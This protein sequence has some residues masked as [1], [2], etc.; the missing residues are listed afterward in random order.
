MAQEDSKERVRQMQRIAEAGLSKI[1]KEQGIKQAVLPFV[2]PITLAIDLAKGAAQAVPQ[3]AIACAVVSFA[4]QLSLNPIEESKK[5]Q[6]G[7][8]HV[9]DR[10]Q[11]YTEL[12]PLTLRFGQNLDKSFEKIRT[13]LKY[14]VVQVYKE[15]LLFLMKSVCWC[16][17]S[18]VVA[19]LRDTI[20]LNDWDG[21]T[22][23]LKEAEADLE[24]HSRLLRGHE[25]LSHV[26]DIESNTLVIK[27]QLTGMLSMQQSL[28][29]EQCLQDLFITYPEYDKQRIESIKG[30]LLRD[31]CR[32]VLQNDSFR[33][34]RDGQENRLLWIK[35]DPGK[36]KTMLL[37]GIIDEL[38][39]SVSKTDRLAYFYCQATDLRINNGVAVLRGLV[40]MLAREHQELLCHVQKKHSGASKSVFQD[41]NAWF[42]L[43]DILSNMIQNSNLG[44]TY[45]VIDALDECI[46]GQQE[47]LELIVELSSKIRSVKWIVSSRNLQ[48]IGDVLETATRDLTISLELNHSSV[49][50]AVE[51]YTKHKVQEL[52]RKKR[53]GKE[54]RTAVLKHLLANA[55]GTFLWVAL[56]C[57]RFPPGLD[58]LYQRMM[59]LVNQSEDGELCKQILACVATVYRPL[60]LEEMAEG[61]TES[62]MQSI[63]SLCGSFITS[64]Q[65][66]RTIQFVHQSAKD[67]LLDH[68]GQWLGPALLKAHE[69]IFHQSLRAMGT[70][71][72]EDVYT[73]LD[74]AFPIQ[75]IETPRPDPLQA[76]RYSC[77]YWV[78]HLV[79]WDPQAHGSDTLLQAFKGV[80]L[81]LRRKLLQW[82]ESLS[83]IRS[84]SEG[85]LALLKLLELLQLYS[86]ALI[87]SPN[88]SLTR[89]Q[90]ERD[91]EIEWMTLKPK[92]ADEWD[93]HRQTLQGH[94]DHVRSIAFSPD[95]SLVASSSEDCSIRIWKFA[96][97]S[98]LQI[99]TGHSE[100]VHSTAFSHDGKIVV[101]GSYDGTIKVW[102]L[103]D[104]KCLQTLA[105]DHTKRVTESKGPSEMNGVRSIGGQNIHQHAWPTSPAEA[106][107]PLSRVWVAFVNNYHS[108][109]DIE[110]QNLSRMS[111]TKFQVN[112]AQ[113]KYSDP[114]FS[115]DGTL[116]LLTTSKQRTLWQTT[117][118]TCL[119]RLDLG[120]YVSGFHDVI[121]PN[122]E[123][124]AVK[125]RQ[126]IQVIHISTKAVIQTLKGLGFEGPTL[127]F[128]PD[129]RFLASGFQDGTVKIW[130]LSVG[131][132][133]SIEAHSERV[134]TVHCSETDNTVVSIS[135]NDIMTWDPAGRRTSQSVDPHVIMTPLLSHEPPLMLVVPKTEENVVHVKALTSH[136]MLYTLEGHD[137]GIYFIGASPDEEILATASADG[138]CRIWNLRDGK[139]T[140]AIDITVEGQPK[141]DTELAFSHDNKLLASWGRQEIRVFD[142]V[143]GN[144][145]QS[146][147]N[148]HQTAMMEFSPN[149]DELIALSKMGAVS[150]WGSSHGQCMQTMDVGTNLKSMAFDVSGSRLVT[151]VGTIVLG[152][153]DRTDETAAHGIALHREGYGLSADGE[154]ITLHGKDVLWLPQD[155]RPSRDW[156]ELA[157][158]AFTKSQVAIGCASGRVLILRFKPPRTSV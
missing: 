57:H 7:M 58:C 108:I 137:D 130:D 1:E 29:D 76:V 86:S 45:L 114:I 117:T 79:E 77:V 48:T 27:D 61:G 87:F 106:A 133:G 80:D 148:H 33:R 25:S 139:C 59:H 51:W 95:M 120:F 123:L 98:S 119:L 78:D 31:P 128:S 11:W 140:N 150:I 125:I 93:A 19:F 28:R 12:E 121:S 85:G 138:T 124:V 71:L 24:R 32:W 146:W 42:V 145:V 100:W 109:S 110:I 116:V 144:L 101:S 4:L 26:S 131:Q 43:S 73:L 153:R 94:T 67:F 115:L 152:P 68:Q 30:G 83:L 70:T 22:K 44:N 149:S 143:T 40:Y 72:A 49:S 20:K 84:I 88:L 91:H 18:R 69:F 5:C 154:W 55:Q 62:T 46:V 66:T 74:P 99:L 9:V 105:D 37:C 157:V 23:A 127:S 63:T 104:G 118:N 147:G 75:R 10:I 8:Q 142:A 151:N 41:E 112:D 136:D 155:Y 122:N 81:F 54:T 89:K 141:Y 34:W 13:R 113:S 102:G 14:Q 65:G 36:G 92:M 21:G 111:L 17:R 47:L 53:Y 38:S 82:L 64:R 56:V 96:T 35:G 16:Y 2:R 132:N 129:S 3:A 6:D 156:R 90:F 52:A 107:D 39:L 126:D 97:G 158:V 103:S 135:L 15:L 50:E 134:L 60:E